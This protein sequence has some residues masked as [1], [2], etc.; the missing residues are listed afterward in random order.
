MI[1]FNSLQLVVHDAYSFVGIKKEN[2]NL[3]FCL[4]KGFE[5]E[6][7][8]LNT[9]S[10]KS[11]TFFLFYKILNVFKDICID[12]GYL[13]E[14]YGL[15]TQDRDGVIKREGGSLIEQGEEDSENI[16][17][18]KLDIIGQLLNAYDEPKILAL[19]YRLG[20]SD[21]I[22]LDK[23]HQYLH[24]A[25]YL[26]NHAVYV[27][28]MLLPKQTV[29]FEST[30]IV[31]MYCYLYCEVKRQLDEDVNGEI[32][33]LGERFRQHY[34]GAE[35]S[36]FDELSYEQVLDTLKDA[37]QVIDNNTVI[38][39]A[40]YWQYY[41]A[42]ELFLYGDWQQK[43]EG[44]I[45]GIKNF[46][47]VWESMSL[48]YLVDTTNPSY[49]LQVDTQFLSAQSINKVN[50]SKKVIDLTGVFDI[51]G[52]TLIPDAVKLVSVSEQLTA[53]ASYAFSCDNWN[54]YGFYTCFSDGKKSVHIAYQ[55]QKEG[56]E[57]YTFEKL[58]EI[59]KVNESRRIVIDS[60]LPENYYS[61]WRIS[62]DPSEIDLH[63][64]CYLNHFFFLGLE[65]GITDWEQFKKSLLEPLNIY[66]RDRSNVFATSLFRGY[67][68][69]V[70]KE[71]FEQFMALVSSQ[72]KTYIQIID[73]KYFLS[74]YFQ[75]KKNTEEIKNRS[76]RKQFVYE[77]LLQKEL[78]LRKT[79]YS[80]SSILS[81]FWLP[82]YR[83]DDSDLLLESSPFID[84]FIQL[85][86]VNFMELVKNYI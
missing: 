74:S 48:T 17:Y 7:S 64:M 82:D 1:N 56:S 83:P 58:K 54:D 18:S 15:S 37:L 45:W 23:I 25:V 86:K 70:V 66:F 28:E 4:P 76:V 24:Q 51:N 46:H 84:G 47:S 77:Y 68:E 33:A 69:I 43:E 42:I 34:L 60:R 20:R 19:A 10:G 12:K 5:S 44:E 79:A 32:T 57:N 41:D 53:L 11:K 67:R 31:T 71:D 8:N 38:K 72:L 52:K 65:K 30:D 81:S 78:E 6:T 2:D 36:L 59:F 73:I 35:D 55:G 39:D 61:Y 22:N 85:V 29:Q 21:K 49:L 62:N 75:N 63:K 14:S 9:F 50:S 40:D 3:V 26:P 16:F 27:D 13:N 80:N